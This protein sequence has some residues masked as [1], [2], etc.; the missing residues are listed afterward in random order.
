MDKVSVKDNVIIVLGNVILLNY[1]VY[2]LVDKVCYD[3][4]IKEVL[5][6]G[7]IKVY[8][9]EGLFIKIDYVKLSLNE[10]YEIIFFFYV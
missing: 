9:G 3:I 2:I 6:E 7:N 10:K 8:K 5:L 4:K 1:D